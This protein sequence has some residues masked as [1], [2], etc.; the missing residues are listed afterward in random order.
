[1]MQMLQ[2]A[3]E[4]WSPVK[5]RAQ[6]GAELQYLRYHAQSQ[7]KNTFKFPIMIQSALQ[8]MRKVLKGIDGLMARVMRG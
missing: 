6:F 5:Q 8:T 2:I 3:V 1:M 7:F 4:R